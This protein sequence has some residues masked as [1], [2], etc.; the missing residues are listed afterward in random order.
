[1]IIIDRKHTHVD[2]HTHILNV[3]WIQLQTFVINKIVD[4]C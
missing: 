4:I 1:M 2:T 3:V